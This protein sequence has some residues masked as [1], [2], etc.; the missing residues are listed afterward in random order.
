M[1]NRLFPIVAAPPMP[2][3]RL[4]GSPPDI[5]EVSTSVFHFN[6]L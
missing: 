4:I 3:G 2:V 1:R 6:T 5:V